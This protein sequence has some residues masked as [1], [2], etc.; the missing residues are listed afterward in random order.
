MLNTTRKPPQHRLETL[1]LA[2]SYVY[3]LKTFLLWSNP[4]LLVASGIRYR[5]DGNTLGLFVTIFD[6]PFERRQTGSHSV[7]RTLAA[8]NLDRFEQW[9][10]YTLRG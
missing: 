1:A 4:N 3:Q 2:I 6:I 8:Q 7:Q 10:R 9:R 5:V